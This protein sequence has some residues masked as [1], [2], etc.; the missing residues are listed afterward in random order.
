[1][2]FEILNFEKSTHTEHTQA[3][4]RMY[5][6][7]RVERESTHVYNIFKRILEMPTY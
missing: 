2:I 5:E 7:A 4:T 1:M 6:H 3:N